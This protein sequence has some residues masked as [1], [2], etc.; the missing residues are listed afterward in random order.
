M[1]HVIFFNS[2]EVFY[3]RPMKNLKKDFDAN[4]TTHEDTP[5]EWNRKLMH[6]I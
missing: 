5:K 6:P 3:G 4:C 1:L 2:A